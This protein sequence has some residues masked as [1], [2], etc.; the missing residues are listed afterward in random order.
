MSAWILIALALLGSLAWSVLLRR[1]RRGTYRV[2]H[3]GE[4]IY[5]F[6]TDMNEFRIDHRQQTITVLS[7]KR[8]R[9]IAIADIRAV[10]LGYREDWAAMEEWL[11]GFD[12]TDLLQD[13]RDRLCWTTIDLE[14]DRGPDIAIY[15][16]GEYQ[17]REF[18]WTWF[19]DGM[20]RLYAR[21]GWI[22]DV[23]ARAQQALDQFVRA[24]RKG[25]SAVPVVQ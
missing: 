12:L 25:G 18:L 23:D 17:E 13:Y 15:A 1:P 21:W 3:A 10:R 7:R 19:I 24:L 11:N 16:I 8:P 9:T 5:G 4:T 6:R 22:P 20:T 2:L 14:L